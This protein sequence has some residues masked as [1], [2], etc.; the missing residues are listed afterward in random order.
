MFGYLL[1]PRSFDSL[2]EILAHKH[3]SLPIAINGIKFIL[4]TTITPIA[5]LN[6]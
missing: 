2:K 1:S 4:T 6:N 5:Y 3:A